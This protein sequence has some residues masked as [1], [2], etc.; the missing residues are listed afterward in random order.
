M[1]KAFLTR[2]IPQGKTDSRRKER[3]KINLP[4]HS[5]IPN[6]I[7]EFIERFNSYSLS[8]SK[9]TA[10]S[11]PLFQRTGKISQSLQLGLDPSFVLVH[12]TF[13][14]TAFISEDR[15]PELK[16]GRAEAFHPPPLL[17]PLASESLPSNTPSD[18]SIA[19]VTSYIGKTE[20]CVALDVIL[21][22]N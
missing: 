17:S 18:R 22:V 5:L 21:V 20:I 4:H 3:R 9:A 7:L 13:C 15:S 2:L 6:I 12:F 14:A 8:V 11:R 16:E 10:A 1:F 19:R